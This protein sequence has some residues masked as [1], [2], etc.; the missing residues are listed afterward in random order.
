MDEI[1]NQDIW[2]YIK[3]ILSKAIQQ[4]GLSNHFTEVFEVQDDLQKYERDLNPE[5]FRG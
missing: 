3:D 2:L 4:S 5:E 1:D